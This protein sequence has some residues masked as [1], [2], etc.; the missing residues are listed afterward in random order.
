MHFNNKGDIIYVTALQD[1]KEAFTLSSFK[2]CKVASI[3][4]INGNDI[5]WNNSSEGLEITPESNAE[6]NHAKVYVV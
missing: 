5:A 2:G 4:T 1:D 6:F 3:K